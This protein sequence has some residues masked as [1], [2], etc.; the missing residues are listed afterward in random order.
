VIL[1]SVIFMFSVTGWRMGI[2]LH[3]NDSVFDHV[4]GA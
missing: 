1:A 3:R 4:K 2:F